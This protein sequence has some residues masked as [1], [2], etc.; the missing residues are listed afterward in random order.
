LAVVVVAVEDEYENQE[1]N[2]AGLVI[3]RIETRTSIAHFP[4][5]CV[6]VVV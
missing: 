2:I 6:K 4:P 5:S 1:G 3:E